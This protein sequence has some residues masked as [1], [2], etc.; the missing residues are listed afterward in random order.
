MVEMARAGRHPYAIR[1]FHISPGEPTTDAEAGAV[2]SALAAEFGFDPEGAVLVRHQK[3]RR[4]HHDPYLGTQGYDRHWHLMVPEIDPVTGRV[5]DSRWMYPR[6]ERLARG[7]ELSLL[8]RVTKGRF[9]T[10]V[11]AAFEKGDDARSARRLREAGIEEGAP[12]YA[13]YSAQQRRRLERRHADP[14]GETLD[15]P[16]LV[17]R[18]AGIWAEHALNRNALDEALRRE[19][20]RLRHPALPPPAERDGRPIAPPPPTVA[21]GWVVDAWDGRARE[22]YVLGAAHMLLREPR[23]RVA[24]TLRA[25]LLQQAPPPAVAADDV[26]AAPKTARAAPLPGGNGV[27][28]ATDSISTRVLDWRELGQSAADAQRADRLLSLV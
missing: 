13:A 27:T 26:P 25:S 28:E 2:V 21:A 5:L 17:R 16:M 10:V 24:E 6:H 1:H 7:A 22:P 18:L 9:N 8:H 11:V 23:A 19:G 12:A 3:P 14:Q 20:L 15:L 4:T